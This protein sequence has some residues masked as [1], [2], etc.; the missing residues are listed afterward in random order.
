MACQPVLSLGPGRVA[1][2][3]WRP[4]GHLI[5]STTPTGPVHTPESFFPGPKPLAPPLPRAFLESTHPSPRK[6]G[7]QRPEGPPS[8]LLS[9]SL[10]FGFDP[11][12]RPNFGNL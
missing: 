3:R 9:T 8:V 11:S 7:S 12:L 4:L 1:V 6:H 5:L 10:L 2:P